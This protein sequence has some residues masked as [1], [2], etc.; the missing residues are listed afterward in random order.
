MVNEHLLRSSPDTATAEL[1][2]A[3]CY[4]ALMRNFDQKWGLPCVLSDF[5]GRSALGT[6]ELAFM[7]EQR[8]KG[9]GNR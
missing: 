3:L 2:G 5:G 8:T 1:R 4:D 9:D 7:G 6:L